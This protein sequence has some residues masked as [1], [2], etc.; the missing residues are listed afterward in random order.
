M[1]VRCKNVFCHI[2]NFNDYVTLDKEYKLLE[3]F[4]ESFV[5]IHDKGHKGMLPHQ[6]FE[7]VVEKV[8]S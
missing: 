1:K 3:I 7:F 4:E 8:D 6:L 2:G 5:I